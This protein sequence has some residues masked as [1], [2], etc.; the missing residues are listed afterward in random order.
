M[1]PDTLLQRLLSQLGLYHP[2]EQRLSAITLQQRLKVVCAAFIALGLV[3]QVSSTL[4]AGSSYILLLASMGSF[5]RTAI[6]YTK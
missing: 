1:T 4:L 6:R 3:A 2:H 5:S